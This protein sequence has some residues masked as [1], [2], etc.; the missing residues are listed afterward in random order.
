MQVLVP[1]MGD[2]TDGVLLASEKDNKCSM[3]CIC[4]GSAVEAG[5]K[6]GEL[7]GELA[8]K[9]GGKGGGKPDFAMGGGPSGKGVENALIAHSLNS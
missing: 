5:H 3:V 9:I 2:F 6:A 1:F 8:Q 7:L 4:S